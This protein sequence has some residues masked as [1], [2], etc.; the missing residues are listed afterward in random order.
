MAGWLRSLCDQAD[1]FGGAGGDGAIKILRWEMRD[2]GLIEQDEAGVGGDRVGECLGL[3]KY[4]SVGMLGSGGSN[5]ICW[6][7]RCA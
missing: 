5:W 2:E 6:T 7:V 1:G 3:E 4:L